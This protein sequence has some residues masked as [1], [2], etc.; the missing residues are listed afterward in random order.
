[1]ECFGWLSIDK[2]R[3][4]LWYEI[5]PIDFEIFSVEI[6]VSIMFNTS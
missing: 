4:W 5:F 6:K 3:E 2:S 1:M